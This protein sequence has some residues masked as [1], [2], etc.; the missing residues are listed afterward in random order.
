MIKKLNLR[1]YVKQ[2][3]GLW[4]TGS[5]DVMFFAFLLLIVVI[6]L[7]MLYSASYVYS[8][9][10]FNDSGVYFRKQLRNALIGLVLMLV[11]SRVNYRIFED[12]GALGGTALAWLLLL[13]ARIMP[14]HNGTHRHI[15]ITETLQFQPSDLAKFTLILTLAA[16]LTK[17]HS[18]IVSKKPL[19]SPLLAARINH[20]VGRPFFNDSLPPILICGVVIA[21]Y[22]GLVLLGSHLSGTILILC[23]GVTMLFLGEVRGKWFVCGGVAAVAA[24]LIAIK[25]NLLKSYMSERIQAFVDKD[26]EPLGAR[27]QIN[28]AL[29]AI[30]SGGLFGKGL[31]NSTMKH[32]Y[33]SEP[34]NDMIFSIVVEELGLVGAALILVVF[35]LLIWRGVVV[36][37][38]CPHRYGALLAMGF[39][40]QLGIQVVLNI[41]VATD[42]VPNTGISLPFFSYGGTAIIVM[43]VQMGVVLGVSRDARIRRR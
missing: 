27:W 39:V 31:G 4:A 24:F 11:V 36:G 35:A 10:Q 18:R 30:G 19:Q 42:T 1:E 29:Y 16:L 25:T 2:K 21:V 5:I 15:Y 32:L 20:A 33:V 7:V 9:Y 6:G 17:Y 40:F 41:L 38:N 12:I 23:I 43:L 13:I 28:Q 3:G 14:A 37:I 8:Y 34:Q 22:A 26:F